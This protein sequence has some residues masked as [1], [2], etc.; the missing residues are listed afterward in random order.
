MPRKQQGWVTFQSSEEERQ[1]LEQHCQVSQRSKTEILREL[2]RSL[3]SPSGLIESSSDQGQNKVGLSQQSESKVMK[4]SARN[5]LR[6]RVKQIVMGSVN[7]E[8][9]LEIAPGVEITSIITKSSA[10]QLD[11]TEGKEAYA[12]I[13]ANNVMIAVD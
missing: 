12:M 6:G 11:L 9:T 4:I 8:V 5:T 1:I 10:E 2:L 3:K 7:A 13:K